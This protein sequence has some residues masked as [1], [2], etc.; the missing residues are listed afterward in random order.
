MMNEEIEVILTDIGGVIFKSYGIKK[1]IS[2][3]LNEGENVANIEEIMSFFY[4]T[5]TKNM[6]ELE[7]WNKLSDIANVKNINPKNIFKN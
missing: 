1:A 3:Y 6:E 4:S 5:F 7:Y 2:Q